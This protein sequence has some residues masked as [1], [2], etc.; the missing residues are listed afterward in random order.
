M[1]ANFSVVDQLHSRQSIE[2]LRNGYAGVILGSVEMY[3]RMLTKTAITRLS[4]NITITTKSQ[5]G[6]ILYSN[7]LSL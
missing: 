7:T 5:L 4:S 1:S 6:F 3:S 2:K